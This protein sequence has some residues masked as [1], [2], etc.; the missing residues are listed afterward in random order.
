MPMHGWGTGTLTPQGSMTE[1]SLLRERHRSGFQ[2]NPMG[3]LAGVPLWL[4]HV[5][6]QELGPHG[7]AASPS[8]QWEH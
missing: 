7:L 6:G 5:G 2:S 4:F 3:N 8:E 1:D